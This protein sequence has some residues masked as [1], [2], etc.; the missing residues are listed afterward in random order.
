[1]GLQ[2]SYATHHSF[3]TSQCRSGC[4]TSDRLTARDKLEPQSKLCAVGE[5]VALSKVF[6]N[7]EISLDVVWKVSILGDESLY[8]IE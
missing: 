4:G 8:Y 2:L 5:E 1:M 3:L 7:S 6:R